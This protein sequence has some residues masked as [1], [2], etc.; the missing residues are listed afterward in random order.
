V[1]GA[2]L[3]QASVN[4]QQWHLAILRSGEGANRRAL[5]LDY[6]SQERHSHMDGMNIGL[7]AKELDIIPDFGY[8][9][10]GYG[11]WGSPKAL[12]YTKTAAHVTATVDGKDQ[13]RGAAG[14]T[15]TLW[16]DGERFRA[17]RASGPQM[18]G[19]EKFERTVAMV[20]MDDA[21]AYVIDCLR[22]TGGSD[23]A[24]FF[25]SYFGTMKATG[26]TLSGGEEY[27]FA[28]ELR[29][30]LT[31]PNAQTGW[32][33]DWTIE[34]RYKYLPDSAQAHLRYTGLTP[35]AVSTCEGWIDSGVGGGS[36]EW[37]PRLMMRRQGNAP[38][39]S[40]FV[41]VIEPYDGAPKLE[42]IERVPVENIDGQA[43][44]ENFV[45]LVLT[46]T[47]AKRD[48]FLLADSEQAVEMLQAQSGIHVVAQAVHVTFGGAGPE[49]IALCGGESVQVGDVELA[50]E[51]TQDF[52]EV[53][54]DGEIAAVVAG[55]PGKIRTIHRAG[56]E[57]TV[58]GK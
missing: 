43:Y 30:F 8:P 10:V 50:C 6:D 15:T 54:L 24:N 18:N 12:W 56:K 4:K 26:L 51:G 1:A 3:P 22:V 37:I 29:N 19:T 21:D 17:V 13:D 41:A 44:G 57:L 14:G 7:F 55:D 47:D 34:D 9:R 16:A 58:K 11:G 48:V 31:D 33:A 42:T 40:T 5:W 20:D 2:A 25:H 28:T 38:L 52:V 39:A 36:P 49:R 46:R 45:G 32:F 27:G 53:R 23:H 35:A